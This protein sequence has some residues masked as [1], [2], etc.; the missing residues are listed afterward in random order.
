VV[1]EPVG[2][3]CPHIVV[4][5]VLVLLLLQKGM[6]CVFL[7]LN[8]LRSL[9]RSRFQSI[10]GLLHLLDLL[11]ASIDEILDFASFMLPCIL[12]LL[13]I[14]LEGVK[15]RVLAR[16]GHALQLIEVNGQSCR[17]LFR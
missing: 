10:I 15:A 4:I 11:E 3:G 16:E 17:I 6:N 12:F 13:E 5:P 1:V 9:F 14:R 7:G 8:F 2:L